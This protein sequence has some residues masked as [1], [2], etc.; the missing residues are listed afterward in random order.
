[1]RFLGINSAGLGSKLSTFKKVLLEL[2]PSVFF[3]E[4]TKFKEEGKLKVDNFV[5]FEH[6]RE[7]RDGGGGIALGCL[8]ELKP[9]LVRK[10]GEGVEA[11]SVDI[12]VKSMKIRCVVAYGCQESSIIEKKN[13]FWSFIEEE[14][15][16]AWNSGLG[17]I[18][19]FDGNLWA[20]SG[21]IPGD[22]RP[23]NKN[24]KLFQDL[25]ARHPNLSVANALPLCEGTITR[26]RVKDGK[27][28]K[29]ILDFF[30][31]CSRVLPHITKMVIDENKKHVLT[32]E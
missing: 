24:G 5:V 13:A 30:V 19:Q 17:F 10:G 6:V 22:P 1:M 14:V 23:Q 18:L 2:R 20:G 28:E 25:L 31:V 16:T 15:I 3:V 9:V 32:K 26:S 11:M 29:S 21:I 4:E 8:K 12:F 27:V 7:T